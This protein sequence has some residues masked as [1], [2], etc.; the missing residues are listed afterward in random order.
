M[1]DFYITMAISILL[2]VLADKKQSDKVK[3]AVLKVFKRILVIYG[4]DEAFQAEMRRFV[5]KPD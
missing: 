4:P 3:S 2:Q 5:V 1:Q